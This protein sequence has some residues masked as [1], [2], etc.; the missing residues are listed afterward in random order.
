VFFVTVPFCPFLL[1]IIKRGKTGGG[2]WG[3]EGEEKKEIFQRPLALIRFSLRF[4]KI[5]YTKPH[6]KWKHNSWRWLTNWLNE[7]ILNLSDPL[8]SS[9][10]PEVLERNTSCMTVQNG[11]RS[12]NE[13]RWSQPCSYFF[14][15]AHQQA[16]LNCH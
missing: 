6:K 16:I 11:V 8:W 5:Y 13:I 9:R 7:L 12:K 3:R 10:Y 4:Y 1:F 14:K 2:A 15:S